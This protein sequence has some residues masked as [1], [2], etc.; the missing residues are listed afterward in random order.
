MSF[1]GIIRFIVIM[2]KITTISISTETHQKLQALGKMGQ[3]FDDVISELLRKELEN[4]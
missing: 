3:T 4:E 2:T 1:I